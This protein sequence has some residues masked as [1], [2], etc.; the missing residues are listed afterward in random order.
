MPIDLQEKFARATFPCK[1]LVLAEAPQA[2]K[3]LFYRLRKLR[4][5]QNVCFI[6]CGSSAS[7]KMFVLSFAEAP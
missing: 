3:S 4:K 2:P 1:V 7:T 5:H 6:I